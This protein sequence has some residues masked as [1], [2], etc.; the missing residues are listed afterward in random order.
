MKIKIFALALTVLASLP[1]NAQMVEVE[2]TI[3]SVL[4][5]EFDPSI[6]GDACLVEVA[7]RNETVAFLTGFEECHDYQ[8]EMWTG[9]GVVVVTENESL[10]TNPEVYGILSLHTSANKIYA[11]D[12]GSIENGLA[13]ESSIILKNTIP[14]NL[15]K[16]SA[17]AEKIV[18]HEGQTK[19]AQFIEMNSAGHL[20]F[21]VR[22]NLHGG[23]SAHEVILTNKCKFVS[24]RVLWAE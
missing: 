16:C 10:V 17:I 6:V 15:E 4:I 5:A 24:K 3:K 13:D 19:P 21:N 7:T 18:R 22:A 23:D 14:E 2:G 1:L 12:F 11:V 8:E 9:R 20:V